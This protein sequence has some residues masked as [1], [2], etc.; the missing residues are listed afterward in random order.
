M[1][2]S[3]LKVITWIIYCS[4]LVGV[5]GN[6]SADTLTGEAVVEGTVVNRDQ[7]DLMLAQW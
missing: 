2:K 7:V 5:G 6:E 3:Q 1:E 4:G